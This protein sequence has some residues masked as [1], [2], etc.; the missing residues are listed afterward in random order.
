VSLLSDAGLPI[1]Q[2]SRLVG[3]SGT[4]T[5]ETIYRKQIRPVIVHGADVMDRVSTALAPCPARGH[6]SKTWPT[7]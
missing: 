1:E 5:T 6:L 7:L 4:A 2:S 3:R